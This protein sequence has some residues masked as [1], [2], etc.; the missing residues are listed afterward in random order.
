MSNVCIFENNYKCA[1]DALEKLYAIDSTKADSLF[2][3]KIAAVASQPAESPDT[4]RL[5]RWTQAGV[6]K[7]PT[8]ST[9][10]SQ[11]LG[12]YA[13]RGEADSMVAV[14]NNLLK[15][16]TTSVAPALLVLNELAKQNRVK[17][18]LPLVEVV[19]QRGT[20]EDKENA[21]IV[22]VNAAFKLLQ[23][24]Q[25]LPGASELA[26][27]AR[28]MVD[29]AT[30]TRAYPNASYALGLANVIQVS[31]MDKETETQKSCD[32][33]RQEDTLVQESLG[34]LTAG[35][36]V[37]PAQVDQYLTYLNSLKART[38]SMIKAYCR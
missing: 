23:E 24:P 36:G 2:Y 20:P 26:R 27:T 10:V 31:K 19:K 15:I 25:D 14:A 29:S 35:R 4:T 28:G 34:A 22:L 18:A 6:A 38:A 11:L 30:S 21:A 12:A 8:N 13:L 1:V 33:A 7:Y 16:D 9:L 17:E 5:I 3:M 37:N 32:M